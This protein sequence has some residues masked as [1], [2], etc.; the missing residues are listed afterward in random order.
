MVTIATSPLSI[1]SFTP[2]LLSFLKLL[3][4]IAT[5]F[6]PPTTINQFLVLGG[7]ELVLIATSPLGIQPFTAKLLSSLKLIVAIVTNATP[8]YTMN[9]KHQCN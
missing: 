3:W 5:N 9:Y 4:A 1:Q 2:K 8:Q 6:T 7:L